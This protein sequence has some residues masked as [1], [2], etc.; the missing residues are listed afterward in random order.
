MR[1]FSIDLVTTTIPVTL[2]EALAIGGLTSKQ[3]IGA[4]LIIA[5]FLHNGLDAILAITLGKTNYTINMYNPAQIGHD[6]FKAAYTKLV[7]LGVIE[8]V[9]AATPAD[10][11][12]R[13]T[14]IVLSEDAKHKIEEFL[15]ENEIAKPIMSQDYE[16]IRLR[17]YTKPS[18]TS[19][20]PYA[21]DAEPVKTLVNY[22]P[23]T[24]SNREKGFIK[25]YNNFLHKASIACEIPDDV[26]EQH[27][28]SSNEL[29]PDK[30]K[31]KL[32][33]ISLADN[34]HAN[35]CYLYRYFIAHD[36]FVKGD[37]F[38]TDAKRLGGRFYCYHFQNLPQTF[39]KYI[40]IDNEP[41]IEIDYS[42]M[43][44][45]ILYLRN[46]AHPPFMQDYRGFLYKEVP[47][48]SIEGECFKKGFIK[49][50]FIIGINC[51]SRDSITATIRKHEKEIVTKIKNAGYRLGSILDAIHKA[52]PFTQGILGSEPI[53]L[54]LQYEDS[55]ICKEVLAQAKRE[56]IVLLPIHDSFICQAQHKHIVKD[57]MIRCLLSCYSYNPAHYDLAM[58]KDRLLKV[59]RAS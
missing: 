20:N 55:V 51:K 12:K 59:K 39:R 22:A 21:D 6:A 4:K 17:A 32:S 2:L 46:P 31:D 13:S 15:Q 41:T 33:L 16:P 7:A 44:L 52:L 47:N 23:S 27:I 38:P 48:P 56:G 26:R 37:K 1:F 9:Y 25:A 57:I 10:A 40:T 8:V 19:L 29:D 42:S 36:D 35:A 45:N 14:E 50:F 28:A 54:R 58:L 30:K 11:G 34:L 5:N 18:T 24:D 3:K 49:P 43:H 53:G